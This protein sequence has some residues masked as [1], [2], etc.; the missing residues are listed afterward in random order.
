[1][2]GL[3]N[4]KVLLAFLSA[5]TIGFTMSSV[6]NWFDPYEQGGILLSRM[7]YVIGSTFIGAAIWATVF[8]GISLLYVR[9]REGSVELKSPRVQKLTTRIHLVWLVLSLLGGINQVYLLTQTS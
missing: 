3:K 2:L 9:V 5:E 8:F 4:Y 6:Q 7:A 1:M